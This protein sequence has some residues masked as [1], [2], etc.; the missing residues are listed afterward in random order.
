MLFAIIWQSALTVASNFAM[1]FSRTDRGEF[2]LPSFTG[3]K[4][5]A[6]AGKKR[7]TTLDLKAKLS[8]N[9]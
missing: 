3:Y 9:F 8:S 2:D 6:C 5:V 1:K 4:G 7:S